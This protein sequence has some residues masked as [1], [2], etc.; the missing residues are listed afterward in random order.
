MVM[1]NCSRTEIGEAGVDGLGLRVR[2][3]TG[4]PQM[5]SASLSEQTSRIA[6]GVSVGADVWN[7]MLGLCIR[8][9]KSLGTID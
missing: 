6:V 1:L 5:L 4:I 7:L 3:H 8:V 2:D 9:G